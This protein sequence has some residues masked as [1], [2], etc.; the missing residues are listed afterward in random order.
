MT[1]SAVAAKNAAALCKLNKN[2]VV[3]KQGITRCLTRK[4]QPVAL[5]K[6]LRNWHFVVI[7]SSVCVSAVSG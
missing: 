6:A 3:V 1:G 2:N 4:R 5:E 7:F